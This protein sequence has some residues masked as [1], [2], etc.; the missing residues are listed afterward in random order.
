MLKENEEL[1]KVLACT[2]R[3]I[4]AVTKSNI[5]NMI[6]VDINLHRENIKVLTEN[7]SRQKMF[8][9]A[10]TTSEDENLEKML[11]CVM[12]G[13]GASSGEMM[14]KYYLLKIEQHKKAIDDL[15]QLMIDLN[16]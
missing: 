13:I 7:I 11:L 8:L 9:T 10:E 15:N 16:I 1:F 6:E 12:E 3:G 14:R 2:M 4:G 5:K